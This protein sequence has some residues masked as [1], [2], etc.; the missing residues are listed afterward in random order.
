M[1]EVTPPVIFPDIEAITLTY[2]R[3]VIATGVGGWGTELPGDLD[4]RLPFVMVSRVASGPQDDIFDLARIDID[5]RSTN[6]ETAHDLIQTV[7]G[8]LRVMHR[9][10]H[11]GAIVYGVEVESAPGWNPDPITDQPR[12]IATVVIRNRPN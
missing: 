12:W 7:L 4:S 8:Y 5:V 11:T 9:Y 6:R 10:P 2:L 1:I 3:G